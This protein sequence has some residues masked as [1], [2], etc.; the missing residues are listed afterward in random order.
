[1]NTIF[2]HTLNQITHQLTTC[3]FCAS[4]LYHE[5]F[6]LSYEYVFIHD[7]FEADV[8]KDQKINKK[9]SL[10]PSKRSIKQWNYC[11]NQ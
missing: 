3:K 11:G 10:S 6:L 5:I 4:N 8:S 2:L 1:M 7:E 9:Y